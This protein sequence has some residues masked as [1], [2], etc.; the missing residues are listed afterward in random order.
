MSETV[1]GL[2]ATKRCWRLPCFAAVHHGP[3]DATVQ[4]WPKATVLEVAEAVADPLD[5]L[6]Q[7]FM[8]SIWSAGQSS[9]MPAEDL[10]L[11]GAHGGGESADLDDLGVWQWAY[12]RSS[13]RRAC[14][15]EVVAYTA[16]ELFGEAGGMDVIGGSQAAK[17]WMRAYPPSVKRSWATSCWRRIRSSG[18]P[19]RPR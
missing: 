16:E 8:V 6:D 12:N 13:R 7:Q 4:Q 10:V 17:V 18:S 5:L 3:F 2:Y 14:R 15:S 11:P 9:A 1:S 19:L